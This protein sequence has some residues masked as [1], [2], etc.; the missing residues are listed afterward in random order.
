MERRADHHGR[1]PVAPTCRRVVALD[2]A[3]HAR[4]VPG[5]H[6]PSDLLRKPQHRKGD[7]PETADARRHHEAAPNFAPPGLP[8]SP[9]TSTLRHVTFYVSP[10][11]TSRSKPPL[12]IQSTPG[13]RPS[14]FT[15][16]H[17]KG[18]TSS[19]S[20]PDH[21]RHHRRR[22]GCLVQV[23]DRCASTQQADSLRARAH[24]LPGRPMHPFFIEHEARERQRERLDAAAEVRLI[25][26]GRAARA[27]HAQQPSPVLRRRRRGFSWLRGLLRGLALR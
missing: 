11:A 12:V 17:M 7:N 15:S 14:T 19:P 13:R 16:R 25:R 3:R 8:D 26:Q 5:R 24:I 18:V 21:V 1:T 27:A 20:H 23:A 6:A 2:L 10:Q 4:D 9:A 22:E